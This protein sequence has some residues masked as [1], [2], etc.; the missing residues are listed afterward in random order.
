MRAAPSRF[1]SAR[2]GSCRCARSSKI[3]GF[4]RNEHGAAFG[5]HASRNGVW[6]DLCALRSAGAEGGERSSKRK[7]L[8]KFCC[9]LAASW[10]SCT[11]APERLHT[12][13]TL[14]VEGV[15]DT[16]QLRKTRA[17]SGS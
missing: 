11:R 8:A 13:T 10:R 17:A 7:K 6:C 3:R 9:E 14:G 1:R 2:N 15:G 5:A 12:R 16:A 4:S